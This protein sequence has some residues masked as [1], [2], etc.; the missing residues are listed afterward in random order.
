MPLSVQAIL[1]ASDSSGT[2]VPSDTSDTFSTPDRLAEMETMLMNWCNDNEVIV[3][4][5]KLDPVYSKV[6]ALLMQ[7]NDTVS[8]AFFFFQYLFRWW[9]GI[10]RSAQQAD[11]DPAC[12]GHKVPE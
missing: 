7:K 1:N 4:A 11:Q 6:S 5:A 10:V 8:R 9:P 2:C 3:L 12:P